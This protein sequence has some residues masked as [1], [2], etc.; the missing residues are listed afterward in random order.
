MVR[1]LPDAI[2]G[3]AKQARKEGLDHPAMTRMV[4]TLSERAERCAQLL[5][6]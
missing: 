6:I 3:I 5:A 1:A 2:R 4:G